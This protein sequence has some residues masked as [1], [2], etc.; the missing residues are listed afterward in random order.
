[1]LYRVGVDGIEADAVLSACDSALI[2][3]A[4]RGALQSG[5]HGA[6]SRAM[7]TATAG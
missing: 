5:G 7:W 4:I 6:R 1:M 2:D 3:A